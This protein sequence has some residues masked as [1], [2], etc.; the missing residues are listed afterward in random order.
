[1]KPQFKWFENSIQIILPV[2]ASIYGLSQ[3]QQKVYR[4]LEYDANASSDLIEENDFGK[5]KVL[6]L[7][8]ELIDQGYVEKI[9]RGQGTRYQVK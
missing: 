6:N 7:L 8:E 1:M 4:A 5:N 9:G 3:N 2:I